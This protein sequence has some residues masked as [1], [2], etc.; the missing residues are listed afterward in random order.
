[1][2]SATLQP[3]HHHHHHHHHHKS[4]NCK[5]TVVESMSNNRRYI[6]EEIQSIPKGRQEGKVD[7][8]QC[9]NSPQDKADENDKLGSGQAQV[10]TQPLTTP[11]AETAILE[12]LLRRDVVFTMSAVLIYRSNQPHLM[13]RLQA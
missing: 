1:M 7:S 12:A 8:P 9:T 13:D 3:L 11:K 10:R 5:V 4:P 6:K 2:C